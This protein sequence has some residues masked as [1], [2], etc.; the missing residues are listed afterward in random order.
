MVQ[1]LAVHPWVSSLNWI[2]AAE[3]EWTF[4][5]AIMERQISVYASNRANL[6]E[7]KSDF[8]WHV[9]SIKANFDGC[10]HY[11]KP[12]AKLCGGEESSL[13]ETLAQKQSRG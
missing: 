9:N 2:A 11:P 12:R 6:A 10:P 8:R 7:M 1:A 3:L 5:S 4:Y 13:G